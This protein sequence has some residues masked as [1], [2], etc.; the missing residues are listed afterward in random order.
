MV[1]KYFFPHRALF[2]CLCPHR[3]ASCSQPCW[4]ACLLVCVSGR[5]NSTA[6]KAWFYCSNPWSML[7]GPFFSVSSRTETFFRVLIVFTT[8]SMEFYA[9]LTSNFVSQLNLA[10]RSQNCSHNVIIF[11]GTGRL[12]RRTDT[13]K[14]TLKF[15]LLFSIILPKNSLFYFHFKGTVSRD[16]LLL[17]FFMNQFPPSPWVYH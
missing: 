6:E 1:L 5:A 8:I 16:F 12:E 13:G 17:V 9:S 11:P 15:F 10:A 4:V 7:Y 2:Q 3:P 14:V